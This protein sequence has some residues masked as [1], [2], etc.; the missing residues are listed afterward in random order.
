[1]QLKPVSYICPCKSLETPLSNRNAWSIPAPIHFPNTKLSLCGWRLYKISKFNTH[2]MLFLVR[3]LKFLKK[4]FDALK[5]L[6]IFLY[7]FDHQ[8]TTVKKAKASFQFL[9]YKGNMFYRLT[10]SNA[11]LSLMLSVIVEFCK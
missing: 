5:R 8:E 6:C 4:F 7:I 10:T 11:F 3:V 9:I 1:M 2:S